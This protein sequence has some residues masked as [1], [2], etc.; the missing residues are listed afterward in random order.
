M[1]KNMRTC[2]AILL[3]IILAAMAM[4]GCGKQSADQKNPANTTEPST[5]IDSNESSDPAED[6]VDLFAD[7]NVKFK[8][9]SGY[10]TATVESNSAYADLEFELS[11]DEGLSNDEEITMTVTTPDGSDLYDYCLNR[12]G[13]VPEADSMDYIVAGLDVP[14]EIDLFEDIDITIS[15]YSP[16]LEIAVHSDYELDGI[17][18]ELVDGVDGSLAIGDTVTIQAYTDYEKHDL[19]KMCL[20]TFESLPT[21]D[22]YTFNISEEDAGYYITE[23][24]QLTD[25]IMAFLIG[26]AEDKFD[27]EGK[28]EELSFSGNTYC[29][30]YLQTLKT[31][32]DA[33]WGEYNRFFVVHEV[34][35]TNNGETRTS[36]NIVEF[37]NVYVNEE[38]TCRF[39]EMEN[40]YGWMWGDEGVADIDDFV[41]DYIKSENEYY[42]CVV[43]EKE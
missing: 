5:Y 26:E 2:M 18:Y 12:Y 28:A 25:D 30:Y 33:Y 9:Y 10:G 13:I 16:Y 20:K 3:M 8:G 6:T 7:V 14:G 29:G 27:S 43:S 22:Q 32:V 24:E 37:I 40:I 36:Y 41:E 4:A 34:N 39:N 23:Q 42:E 11:Q 21:S 38:G 31:W 15:G 19:N 35:Y 1:K 17:Y